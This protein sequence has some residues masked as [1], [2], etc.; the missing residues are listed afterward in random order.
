MFS[1]VHF[2]DFVSVPADPSDKSLGYF[3][4]SAKRGLSGTYFLDKAA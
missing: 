2:A 1:A 4:P 3:Q